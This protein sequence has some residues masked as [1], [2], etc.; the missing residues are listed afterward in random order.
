[1]TRSFETEGIRMTAGR[2]KALS[3]LAGTA[4]GILMFKV[5]PAAG[6]APASIL[7]PNSQAAKWDGDDLHLLSGQLLTTLTIREED[8]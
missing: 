2:G 5:V 8:G 3:V 1:M 7:V 6:G 4:P